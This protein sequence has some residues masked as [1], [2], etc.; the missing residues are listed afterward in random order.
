[1]V[2]SVISTPKVKQTQHFKKGW[3]GR[4]LSR[5][6]NKNN[7]LSYVS[8]KWFL[9]SSFVLFLVYLLVH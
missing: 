2:T 9:E 1:M 6:Y 3:V 7:Y 5:M 4:M 8:L